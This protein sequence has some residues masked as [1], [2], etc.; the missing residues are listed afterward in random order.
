MIVSR[1]PASTGTVRRTSRRNAGGR[2]PTSRANWVASPPDRSSAAHSSRGSLALTSRKPTKERSPTA[3][4]RRTGPPRIRAIRTSTIAGT[5]TRIVTPDRDEP[6]KIAAQAVEV[7]VD[8]SPV[9]HHEAEVEEARDQADP[10]PDSRT[11]PGPMPAD[12]VSR[13]AG[14]T[15]V[16]VS[17]L[18]VM[19]GRTFIEA[20]NRCGQTQ[21]RL[22]HR[23]FTGI[24]IG[25]KGGV[26]GRN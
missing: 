26:A 4:P 14:S 5:N 20:S 10:E 2:R 16:V 3:A 13:A 6:G 18:M 24:A 11:V 15:P 8:Q 7:S 17:S 19:C 21:S 25:R 23:H 22:L 12:S 1:T 9:D